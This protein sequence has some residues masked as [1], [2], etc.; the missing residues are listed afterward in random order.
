MANVSF[1]S[2]SKPLPDENSYDHRYS[3]FQLAMLSLIFSV[4]ITVTVVGNIL[5]IV[6]YIRDSRIRATVANL[7]ILNLSITDVLVGAFSLTFNISRFIKGFWPHGEI[8]CKLW[9]VLDYSVVNISWLS[10]IL[11]SRD[12]YLLVSMGLKYQ[13]YQTKKRVGL[14]LVAIWTIVVALWVVVAFA[15]SP[16]TGSYSVNYKTTCFM[17]YLTNPIAPIFINLVYFCISF[18]LVFVMN[19]AVYLKVRQRSKGTVGQ[20]P[21]T[22][23]SA[24]SMSRRNSA[25]RAVLVGGSHLGDPGK[26]NPG[27]NGPGS[28]ADST[29]HTTAGPTASHSERAVPGN[30][31]RAQKARNDRKALVKH[32]KAAVV[33]GILTGCFLLCWLPYIATSVM[34]SFCGDACIPTIVWEITE[35]IAWC[36]STINPF[37]YAATNVHFR[38]NFKRFLFLDRWTCN[39]IGRREN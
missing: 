13:N 19:I 34:F 8:I 14:T 24:E 29:I 2:A 6:A 32:Q 28:S 1:P 22:N 15:W 39:G 17:E 38:K 5:V 3:T 9:S 21:P 35:V 10:I 31:E 26:A 27:Q 30:S 37:I 12:R 16:I 18:I 11:I 36:N 23:Q 20:G 33:L 7:F 25:S 4:I